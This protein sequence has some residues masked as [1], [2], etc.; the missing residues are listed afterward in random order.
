MLK[1][2]M[3]G[4]VLPFLIYLIPI[5]GFLYYLHTPEGRKNP[6]THELLVLFDFHCPVDKTA[7][8]EIEG[9]R[10]KRTDASLEYPQ[11]APQTKIWSLN[12]N[13]TTEF[14]LTQWLKRKRI[15][16]SKSFLYQHQIKCVEVELEKIGLPKVPAKAELE[17]RLNEKGTLQY[18]GILVKGLTT[19]DAQEIFRARSVHL[20][21]HLGVANLTERK[22]LLYSQEYRF[23]DYSVKLTAAKLAKAGLSFFEQHL[24]F[25]EDQNLRHAA[26][27]YHLN[28]P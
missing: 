1:T 8:K 5:A 20:E 13:Q 19:L 28:E 25:F 23:N 12:L 21:K 24:Y 2:I 10:L 4:I 26:C 17:F 11:F 18:V 22:P 27:V 7:A 9:L 3:L 16:C 14:Q 15:A 6:V